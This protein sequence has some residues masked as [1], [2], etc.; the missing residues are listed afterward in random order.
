MVDE[1]ELMKEL[2]P[3]FAGELSRHLYYKFLSTVPLFRN[4]PTEIIDKLCQEVTPMLATRQQIVIQEGT[5]GVEMYFVM[6]GEVEVTKSGDRLGFLSEGS[7]FGE[8]PLI[9]L[10]Y[11]DIQVQCFNPACVEHRNSHPDAEEVPLHVR[12]AHDCRDHPDHPEHM[13]PR[14]GHEVPGSEIRTRTV[15]AVTDCELCY[16]KRDQMR[17][18]Q[19]SNVEL[20]KRIRRFARAGTRKTLL[21]RLKILHARERT[22]IERYKKAEVS[23]KVIGVGADVGNE[24]LSTQAL[25]KLSAD[26]AAQRTQVSDVK[27]DVG[28]LK[29]Q[30]GSIQASLELLVAAQSSKHS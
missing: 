7:F 29:T 2:P 26:L 30:M 28:E 10:S 13:D 3:L 15:R 21:E 18:L 12:E 1:A 23:A 25:D 22:E 16:L 19:K 27:Q 6:K 9:A 14:A 11:P 4:L 8:I 17:E 24:A 5:P 20:E